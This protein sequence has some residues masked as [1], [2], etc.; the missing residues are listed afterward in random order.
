[1]VSALDP[2]SDENHRPSAFGYGQ[3]I[4]RGYAEF[5]IKTNHPLQSLQLLDRSRYTQRW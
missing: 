4:Y 2:D 3:A 1:V 5:L